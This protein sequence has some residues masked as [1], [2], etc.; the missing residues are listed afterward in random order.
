MGQN[1]TKLTLDYTQ[2]WDIISM[3]SKNF[4]EEFQTE[5]V[6]RLLDKISPVK[7]GFNKPKCFA[8]FRSE[9]SNTDSLSGF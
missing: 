8:E 7:Y 1:F 4:E 6:E 3:K 2:F 9:M 5:D